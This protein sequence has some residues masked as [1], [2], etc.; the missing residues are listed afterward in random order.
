MVKVYV[1]S[2][3]GDPEIVSV[4][5]LVVAVRASPGGNEPAETAHVPAVGSVN[6]AEV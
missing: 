2:D 5:A 3:V 1:P 4:V 6:V